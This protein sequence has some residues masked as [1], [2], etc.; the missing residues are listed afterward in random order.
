MLSFLTFQLWLGQEFFTNRHYLT[1]FFK[2]I[3][4][5][6]FRVPTQLQFTVVQMK[7]ISELTFEDNVIPK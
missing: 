4:F 2:L 6:Y 7:V 5:S 1:V 3:R